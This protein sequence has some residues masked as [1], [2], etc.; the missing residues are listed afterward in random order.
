MV[1]HQST[2]LPASTVLSSCLH[3]RSVASHR[4]PRPRYLH[5]F[6]CLHEVTARSRRQFPRASLYCV[7]CVCSPVSSQIH[8][9]DP[10]DVSRPDASGLWERHLS[11]PVEQLF[12]NIFLFTLMS[13]LTSPR[14][15]ITPQC[16]GHPVTIV[17]NIV[18]NKIKYRVRVMV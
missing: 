2:L 10:G 5:R 9:P 18:S 7:S 4:C 3:R 11:G 16:Q 13:S 8:T 14:Y 1:R 12:H 15:R 17:K 6:R